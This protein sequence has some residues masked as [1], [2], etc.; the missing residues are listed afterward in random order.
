MGLDLPLVDAARIA[1]VGVTGLAEALHERR[2]VPLPQIGARMDAHAV[3]PL[4]RHG[5][6]AEE[7]LDGQRGDE[8]LDLG[9]RDREEPVGLAVVRGDL[10]QHLVDRHAGR[11]R[12]L[13]PPADA[14]LDLAGDE[15]RRTFVRHVQK[16][17]VERQ[18][19]HQF[20][21]FAEDVADLLRDG[22]V[23]VETRR[24]EDQVGAQPPRRHGGKGRAHAVGTRLVAGR[25]DHAARPVVPHGDRTAPQGGVV[26]LLDRGVEGV[27]VDVYDLP[28]RHSLRRQR[29]EYVRAEASASLIMPSRSI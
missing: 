8:R 17:F 21:I 26:A 20:G 19:L 1:V 14:G 18:R 3:H 10:G 13:R 5:T 22:L 27:H 6:D 24:N 15:R 2:L 16:G 29:Y 23:D 12:Q 7:A 11:S 28:L 25:R 9:G 4:G